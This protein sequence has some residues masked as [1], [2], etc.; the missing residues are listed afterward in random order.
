MW[1]QKFEEVKTLDN[2]M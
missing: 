2:F 1:D